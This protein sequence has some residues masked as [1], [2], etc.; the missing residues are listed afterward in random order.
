MF[1][2]YEEELTRCWLQRAQEARK[3][4]Q[5]GSAGFAGAIDYPSHQNEENPRLF[6]AG[7]L[8]SVWINVTRVMAH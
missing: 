4:L 2:I 5:R 6:P 1:V 3:K 8:R 7:S